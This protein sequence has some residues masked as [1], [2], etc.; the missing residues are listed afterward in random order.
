MAIRQPVNVPDEELILLYLED[1]QDTRVPP[2]RF[3]F[4]TYNEMGRALI[5]WFIRG[6]TATSPRV[7]IL[8]NDFGRFLDRMDFDPRLGK[9]ERSQLFF[10]GRTSVLRERE[11]EFPTER[12]TSEIVERRLEFGR[13]TRTPVI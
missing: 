2:S 7:Q 9:R 10:D 11:E 1:L 12:L 3:E 4:R 13:D 6:K 8:A 5:D